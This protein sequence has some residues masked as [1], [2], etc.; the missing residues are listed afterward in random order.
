MVVVVVSCLRSSGEPINNP[1]PHHHWR[2]NISIPARGPSLSLYFFF[3]ISLKK[4]T[5]VLSNEFF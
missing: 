1:P 4:Q 5:H 3:P 2:R